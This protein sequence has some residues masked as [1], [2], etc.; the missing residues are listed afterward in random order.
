M[1]NFCFCLLLCFINTSLFA[2]E[3]LNLYSARQEVLMRPLIQDFQ[4]KTGIKINIVSA[5]ADQL[6]QRLYREGELTPADLLLTTDAARLEKAKRL[7]LLQQVHSTILNKKI[8]SLYRD[9]SFFWY[10]LSLR[11][12][13]I[14]YNKDKI[15]AENL[16]GT[17]YIN[18]ADKKFHKNIFIRSSSNV[19]N[20]SLIAAMI[21]NYGR[22][23][24]TAFLKSFVKNFAR[25]PSGGDRDQIK[26][27]AHGKGSIAVVNSYYYFKLINT[28][29]SNLYSNTEIYFPYDDK[30]GTHVN[31]S[32][33]GVTKFSK[34][35]A[36]ALKFLEYLVSDDAQMI[37]SSTN[38]EY[39]IVKNLSVPEK[40]RSFTSFMADD[41]S[42]TRL[43]DLNSDAV[44]LCDEAGWR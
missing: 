3:F 40:L 25:K 21:E 16:Q 31:I 2:K 15:S 44:I 42:M 27:V 9:K 22:E 8:P 37:Y 6:M 35:K 14:I 18:L 30:M 4:N 36:N 39:P 34:N 38:Y 41:I 13:V 5:K 24:T 12:R 7:D 11:V 29:N 43:G 33:A 23:A 28:E 19:Y 1:K 26:A 17:G 20:Q 10:G 32:G